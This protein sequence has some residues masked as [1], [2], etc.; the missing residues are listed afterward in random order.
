MAVVPGEKG[1]RAVSTYRVVERFP[2]HTL[3][4]VH[5][6]TGRTHQ[7]RLHLAF[8]GSPVA[9]DR[10]YGRRHSTIPVERHFLHAAHL[11]IRLPGEE[12]ATSFEAPLPDEL[13]YV[14]AELRR[15]R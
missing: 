14:L 13:E 10:T 3:L 1:R 11:S 9:G 12:Q 5:P 6:E 15:E 4:E 7:I 8:I 2:Q